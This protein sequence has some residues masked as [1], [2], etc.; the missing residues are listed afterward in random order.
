MK[1]LSKL[2][3]ALVK[4]HRNPYLLN[5]V[6]DQEEGHQKQL[7]TEGADPSKPKPGFK[8]TIQSYKD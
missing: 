3:R 5:A 1:S 7:L 2:F 6:L 4:V 8:L